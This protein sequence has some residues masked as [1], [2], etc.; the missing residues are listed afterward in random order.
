M[1]MK[2]IDDI[3][4]EVTMATDYVFTI[5]RGESTSSTNLTGDMKRFMDNICTTR[6]ILRKTQKRVADE[7]SQL[8]GQK[9]TQAFISNFELK[10]ISPYQFLKFKPAFFQKWFRQ[11]EMPPTNHVEVLSENCTECVFELHCGHSVL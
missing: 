8:S 10:A 1:E 7:V 6:V 2:D 3:P 5:A 4:S 11:Q 9:F